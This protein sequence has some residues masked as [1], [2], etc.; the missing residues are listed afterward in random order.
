MSDKAE[1][2]TPNAVQSITLLG[3]KVILRPFIDTDI[4][5]VYINWLNDPDVVRYSNQ[6]FRSHDKD[7]CLDYLAS[8]INS[9]NFF[10]SVRSLSN[11]RLLGTLT[12]YVSNHHSTVDVGIMMG[13]K[14]VWGQG[15][16][17]DAWNTISQWLLQE[18][19]IRKLTAGTLKCNYGMVKIMERSG[20]KLEAV[21]K[22]QEIVNNQFVDVLYYSKFNDS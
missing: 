1:L 9:T 6:R 10:M 15:Y 11:E 3:D 22:E 8:F 21:R 20:M 13:D 2:V 7:S 18:Q 17:Q 12:A 16:G 4:G 19:S 14:S 5:D